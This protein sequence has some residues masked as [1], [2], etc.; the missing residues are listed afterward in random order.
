MMTDHASKCMFKVQMKALMVK[1]G[2]Q[3][4]LMWKQSLTVGNCQ[5]KE[6]LSNETF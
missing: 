1:I 5:E 6:R 4:S 3:C 2:Y